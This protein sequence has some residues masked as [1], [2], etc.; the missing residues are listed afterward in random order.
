MKLSFAK[1]EKG[2]SLIIT[3]LVIVSISVT[4]VVSLGIS[5]KAFFQINENFENLT[6]VSSAVEGA[7][8]ETLIHAEKDSNWP[9]SANFSDL[10]NFENVE[11]SRTITTTTNEK[12]YFIE[13]TFNG[14][15]QNLRVTENLSTKEFVF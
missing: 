2:Q 10:Y 14:V 7:M 9:S 6:I 1:N 12:I 8:Q 13:G 3:I 5:S 4:L 15:Y 11:I